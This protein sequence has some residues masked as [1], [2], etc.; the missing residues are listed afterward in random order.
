[1]N[2]VSYDILNILEQGGRFI[3][4]CRGERIFLLN[5][6]ILLDCDKCPMDISDNGCG[7]G[8]FLDSR[9][10]REFDTII[11]SLFN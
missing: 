10:N 8:E 6:L 4:C 7:P 1:M 2:D 3:N 5:G 11:T 9:N